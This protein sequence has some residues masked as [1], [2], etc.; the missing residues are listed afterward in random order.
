MDCYGSILAKYGFVVYW[1]QFYFEICVHPNI[2]S[3]SGKS[4]GSRPEYL[5]MLAFHFLLAVYRSNQIF[6]E[7]FPEFCVIFWIQYSFL[8]QF[9]QFFEDSCL[10]RGMVNNF[11]RIFGCRKPESV[12][13]LFRFFCSEN[14]FQIGSQVPITFWNY[15]QLPCPLV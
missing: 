15:R 6:Q 5:Q 13:L 2:P 8:F 1:C 3:L 10:Y 11:T 4:H 7:F 14:F 12:T 9:L